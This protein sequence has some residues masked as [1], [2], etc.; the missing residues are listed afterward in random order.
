MNCTSDAKFTANSLHWLLSD[1]LLSLTCDPSLSFHCHAAAT[2][3]PSPWQPEP[4]GPMRREWAGLTSV[5]PFTRGQCQLANMAHSILPYGA[6]TYVLLA[7]TRDLGLQRAAGVN[8]TGPCL[9]LFSSWSTCRLGCRR[10]VKWFSASQ[11]KKLA[12]SWP[13][14][15]ACMNI[16]FYVIM[17]N[18]C[19]KVKVISTSR[20]HHIE[21]I[22]STT[23]L[24]IWRLAGCMCSPHYW[25]CAASLWHCREK[26][27]SSL[28]QLPMLTKYIFNQT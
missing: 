12:H 7:R 10:T 3:H 20:D 25:S 14:L 13:V 15:I 24:S 4:L 1:L 16:F 9:N 17:G 5:W 19:Y 18:I 11:W 6:T 26:T 21:G 22:Q 28:T 27:C 2:S 8:G 23:Q